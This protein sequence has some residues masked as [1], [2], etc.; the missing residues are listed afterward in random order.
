MIDRL[1]RFQGIS[2]FLELYEQSPTPNTANLALN[3]LIKYS[4]RPSDAALGKWVSTRAF[5]TDE[6]WTNQYLV[7]TPNGV[8]K[9]FDDKTA[10][11]WNASFDL[12]KKTESD[13]VENSWMW[14]FNMQNE[15]SVIQIAFQSA[16]DIYETM[17]S[18]KKFIG[19]QMLQENDGNKGS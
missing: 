8:M 3:V 18:I 13:F 4:S 7:I 12:T 19:D 1:M 16:D 10:K 14:H 6:R 15:D 2:E 11:K 9:L 5:G 17:V